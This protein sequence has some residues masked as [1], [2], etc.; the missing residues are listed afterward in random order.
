MITTVKALTRQQIVDLLRETLSAPPAVRAA[1][2]GGSDASGRGP[3]L[4]GS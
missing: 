2:L 4:A 1:W 3:L